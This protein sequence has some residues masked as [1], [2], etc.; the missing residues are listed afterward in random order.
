[1]PVE[2]YANLLREQGVDHVR[3]RQGG[4]VRGARRVKRS[5]PGKQ[6]RYNIRSD[7]FVHAVMQQTYVAKCSPHR[8]SETKRL[9]YF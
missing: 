3:L 6:D 5:P 2:Q 4:R 7:S 9:V 8:G 1:M